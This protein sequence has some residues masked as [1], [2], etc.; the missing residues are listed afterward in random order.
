MGPTDLAVGSGVGQQIDRSRQV[1]TG[2][3][4]P[5]STAFVMKDVSVF[6]PGCFAV[7]SAADCRDST[8]VP[9]SDPPAFGRH[10]AA[11]GSAT[12]ASPSSGLKMA[13]G[14]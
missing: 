4:I 3:L 13:R 5:D 12:S 2:A 14:C 6:A 9:E 11:A 1:E 7:A 8:D 10:A